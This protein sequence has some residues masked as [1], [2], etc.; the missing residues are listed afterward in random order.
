MNRRGILSLSAAAGLAVLLASN[1]A[2]AQ[3]QT[4]GVTVGDPGPGGP[5][6]THAECTKQADD[7]KLR[8]S[9]RKAFIRRCMKG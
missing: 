7:Q 9:M 1:M 4:Q 2:F 5:K 6:P 3:L 8:G